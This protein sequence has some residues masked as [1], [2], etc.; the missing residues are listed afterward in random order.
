LAVAWLLLLGD[1]D[2]GLLSIHKD[3]RRKEF[4]EAALHHIDALYRNA[5]HLTRSTTEAEDLVQETYLKACRFYKRFEEGTNLKAWLFRIQFNTYINRYRRSAK[6]RSVLESIAE[7]F[8]ESGV[9]SNSTKQQLADS[10]NQA[11][12]SVV[13]ME[14]EKAIEELPE[15]YRLMV[16]LA[17]VEELNYREI[18]E[19][20]GC[21]IGTVMSRL[22]RA[23]QMLQKRLID[24]AE[25]L[26][27]VRRAQKENSDKEEILREGEEPVSLSVYR[28]N[29]STG[30]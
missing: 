7:Q 16:M 6:E 17:D 28:Q 8:P 29:R 22:Y 13:G 21:P 30:R 10:S 1:D 5:I 19:I 12:W 9:M 24:H 14:I 4:E 23:R 11:I 20:V 15:D 27:F 18:A 26:G 25:A 3:S 2:M